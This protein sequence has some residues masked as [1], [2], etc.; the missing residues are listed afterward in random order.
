MTPKFTL[1]PLRGATAPTAQPSTPP[2]AKRA[3]RQ[4]PAVEAQPAE[5]LDWRTLAGH[6]HKEGIATVS[7][8]VAQSFEKRTADGSPPA[9]VVVVNAL[10][11]VLGMV[12]GFIDEHTA[13]RTMLNEVLHRIGV[14]TI[15]IGAKDG[16]AAEA[17]CGC[18]AVQQVDSVMLV[19]CELHS[20]VETPQVR[21]DELCEAMELPT[22]VGASHSIRL[23][24]AARRMDCANAWG[25]IVARA[26]CAETDDATA[27]IEA[28]DAKC[29]RADAAEGERDELLEIL[30][31]T[32]HEW[33]N[34][35]MSEREALK[36]RIAGVR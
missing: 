34:L 4:R 24:V 33:A 30:G 27:V 8:I 26:G 21:L 9:P 18:R 1:P 7:A 35:G 25:D 5:R 3:R 29:V 32:G 15:T 6:L 28:L 10:L 13:Q 12:E 20:D 23:E 16:G 36:R 11:D 14:E 19:P 31:L 2:K 17:A 22:G